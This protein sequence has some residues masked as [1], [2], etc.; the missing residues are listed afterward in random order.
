MARYLYVKLNDIHARSEIIKYN[1]LSNV[2][3]TYVALE[4]VIHLYRL[5]LRA[6]SYGESCPV[7]FLVESRRIHF[8]YMKEY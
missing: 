7:I 5:T 6:C 8:D 2:R 1:F 4:L 3:L